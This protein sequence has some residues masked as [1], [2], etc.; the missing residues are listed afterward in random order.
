MTDLPQ[1]E[2]TVLIGRYLKGERL[3]R[4]L[5]QALVARRMGCTTT[6]VSAIERGVRRITVAAMVSYCEQIGLNPLK[7]LKAVLEMQN[8][9]RCPHCAR[10]SDSSG[11]P[12]RRS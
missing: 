6:H 11:N 12:L 8:P 4:N 7:A 3:R 2:L 5:N 1:D 10:I 9:Q